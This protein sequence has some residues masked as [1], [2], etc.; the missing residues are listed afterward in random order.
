MQPLVVTWL[1][2]AFRFLLRLVVGICVLRSLVLLPVPR[3]YPNILWPVEFPRLRIVNTEQ[4][5]SSITLSGVN[6]ASIKATPI[7]AGAVK[8]V[9]M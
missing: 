8:F 4:F 1:I 6:I 7:S 3:K 9:Q 5:A 2:S